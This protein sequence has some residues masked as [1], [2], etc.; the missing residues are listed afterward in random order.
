MLR[1]VSFCA[2]YRSPI[3]GSDAIFHGCEQSL[4]RVANDS[5][6]ALWK[7]LHG[8]TEL[9]LEPL[10]GYRLKR[11]ILAVLG[12]RN[13]VPSP[14]KFCT[15]LRSLRLRH[16][17][18]SQRSICLSISSQAPKTASWLRAVP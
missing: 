2:I 8:T 1:T 10:H 3:R 15:G 12:G 16:P 4:Q 13:P 6:E 18:Q 14:P 17:A 11:R 9:H 7:R 5:N